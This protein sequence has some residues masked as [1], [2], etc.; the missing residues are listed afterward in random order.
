MK[1][2]VRITIFVLILVGLLIFTNTKAPSQHVPWRNLNPEA[3]IGLATKTQLLRLSLS[4][5]KTCMD[6]A[7]NV[8]RF[9]SIPAEPRITQSKCGFKIARIVE[10]TERVTLK[11]GEVSMQC[12]LSLGS[13]IWIQEIE[14]LALEAFASPLRN[15]HHMGTY[16]CRRQKGNGSGQWSEHSFSNAWDIA[17]FELENG[18]LIN[19]RTSWND[20]TPS[21]KKFLRDV[22]A[23]ACKIFKVVL[24]PDYNA[25][26]YD[27]FHVDMGP[28]ATCR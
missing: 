12:P 20:G 28:S 23:Q 15:I 21:E 1:M 18:Q 7:R 17:S 10:G 8:T 27:H 22:R 5:S 11:P 14:R 9:D 24:S 4:A 25:A 19:I 3:P 2:I 6:M 16:S 26:H 13:Y